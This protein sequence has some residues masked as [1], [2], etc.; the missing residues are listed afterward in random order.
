M[1]YKRAFTTKKPTDHRNKDFDRSC[2]LWKS[3]ESQIQ[4]ADRTQHSESD[5]MWA[6]WLVASF[7]RIR[8]NL[9]RYCNWRDKFSFQIVFHL[10]FLNY[11]DSQ[12]VLNVVTV[13]YVL[14]IENKNTRWNTIYSKGTQH[15]DTRDKQ[16]KVA[17]GRHNGRSRIHIFLFGGKL[18]RVQG[19]MCSKSN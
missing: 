11:H 15:G 13:I 6:R 7:W 16:D 17:I 5:K 4:S 3:E 14:C 8:R 18:M 19:N 12:R 9:K 2:R 10:L 1:L